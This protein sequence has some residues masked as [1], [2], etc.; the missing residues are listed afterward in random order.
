MD[1]IVCAKNQFD[2]DNGA[3]SC[4]AASMCCARLFLDQE[5]QRADL[6]RALHAGATLY[7]RWAA[8]AGNHGLQMWKD[9]VRTCP[10][11]LDRARTVYEGNGLFGA[12]ERGESTVL[13]G[14]VLDA[15][16]TAAADGPVAGV[17]TTGG[18]SYMVGKDAQYWYAFDPH[19]GGSTMGSGATFRRMQDRAVLADYVRDELTGAAAGAEFNVVLFAPKA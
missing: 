19:G 10:R 6:E 14:D 9:V 2:F 18:A 7:G 11:Y 1:E 8:G 13:Y 15:C 3:T 4:M 16:E 17:L 5:L 12:T